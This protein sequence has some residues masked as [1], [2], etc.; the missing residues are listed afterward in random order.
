[1]VDAPGTEPALR[2]LEATALAEQHV[3]GRDPDIFKKNFGVAMRRL[4]IAKDRQYPL[5]NDAGMRQRHQYHRLP[6]ITVWV[7]GIRLAH[8]DHDL[9]ARIERPR[10]PPFATVDDVIIGVA[11]DLRFDVGRVRGSY[12]GLGHREGRADFAGEPRIEP[13]LAL[14]HRAV[15]DQDLHV[16]GI[17]RRAV[18]YLGCPR[19][20][21]HD[22]AERRVF[23]VGQTG[24][25]LAFG[26]EEVP[27]LGRPRS[28][29][30]AFEE[31]HRLP[32]VAFADLCEEG[33]FVR[34]DVL[35]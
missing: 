13:T 2:D 11:A 4:V 18:E 5:D 35:R 22:L 28:R 21:T 25:V 17:R 27:Q 26:Q 15:S 31:R 19:R 12:V 32:S 23:E 16:A 8:H 3:S 29:L 33:L 14:L 24:T 9:A 1:M 34:L 6:P 20:A 30:Q 10:G 7:V